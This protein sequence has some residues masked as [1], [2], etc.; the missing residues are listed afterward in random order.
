MARHKALNPLSSGTKSTSTTFG[1][2]SNRGWRWVGFPG[3]SFL[4]PDRASPRDFI[5]FDLRRSLFPVVSPRFRVGRERWG[6]V[7]FPAD[8]AEAA[9]LQ[10]GPKSK[11]RKALRS[12]GCLSGGRGTR[13]LVFA[14]FSMPGIELPNGCF[15]GRERPAG[16][17]F[18]YL[19]WG[20]LGVCSESALPLGSKPGSSRLKRRKFYN[21]SGPH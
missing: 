7:S 14:S 12:T 9:S 15:R 20:L 21:Y 5:G 2:G 17:A 3:L 8:L 1:G 10:L 19:V 18:R 13:S 4:S 11:S 16:N 6:P